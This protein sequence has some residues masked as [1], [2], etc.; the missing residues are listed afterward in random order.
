MQKIENKNKFIQYQLWKDCS[1]GC[2]F[3]CN[4]GQRD[5]DKI[6]SLEFVLRKLDDPQTLDFNQVGFIGGQFFN[7]QIEDQRVR[8]LFYK[9]F[10]R[11]SSMHFQ[12]IY[13]TTALSFD[14]DK[15]F[16]PFL[17][18]MREIKALDKI[19]VCTSYDPMYRFRS[20]AH[21]LLWEKNIFQIH[22]RFPEAKIHTQ[23]IVTQAFIDLVLADKF[24]ILQFAEKLQTSIDYIQ[25]ES[26]LYY[27]GKEDASKDMPMFFPTKSSFIKFLRKVSLQNKWINLDVFLSMQLRSS[28]LYYI[29]GG[30]RQV[31]ENRRSTNGV[32]KPVDKTVKFQIGFIDSDQPMRDVILRFREMIG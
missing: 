28:K 8:D 15:L 26:G 25:P 20:E 12:K 30:Q 5:L 3:C 27:H 29:D 9:V 18:H 6:Q 2:K 13:V 21:K 24:N 19:L 1:L 17:E 23:I 7:K 14:L 22:R 10:Q 11:A 16:F 32:A 31:A 4:K